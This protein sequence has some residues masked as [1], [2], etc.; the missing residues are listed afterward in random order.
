MTIGGLSQDEA[1]CLRPLDP[2]RSVFNNV[3]VFAN[4]NLMVSTN[5]EG[6][7]LTIASGANSVLF[8]DVSND[9]FPTF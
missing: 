3:L 1:D 4:D 9:P 6:N 7:M 2:I 8:F 5:P